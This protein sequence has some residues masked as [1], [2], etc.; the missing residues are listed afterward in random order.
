MKL[1][2]IVVTGMKLFPLFAGDW[3]ENVTD[4]WL[5]IRILIN[6]ELQLKLLSAMAVL[7]ESETGNFKRWEVTIFIQNTNM[8]LTE[9]SVKKDRSR[10]YTRVGD[11]QLV[12]SFVTKIKISLM[13][14][15]YE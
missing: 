6:V 10:V 11:C 12:E 7:P 9:A 13:S 1:Y 15:L 3:Y 5:K 8:L 4:G 14:A 2:L